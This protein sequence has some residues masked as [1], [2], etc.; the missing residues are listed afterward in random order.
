MTAMTTSSSASRSSCA[1]ASMRASS[2]AA[3]TAVLS[4]PRDE[5]FSARARSRVHGVRRPQASFEA[6]F[7]GHSGSPPG[8]G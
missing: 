4:C 2:N 8:S 1:E 7:K 5:R 6:R 3:R